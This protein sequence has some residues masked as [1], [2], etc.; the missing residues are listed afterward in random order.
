MVAAASFAGFNGEHFSTECYKQLGCSLLLAL[1]DTHQMAPQQ[2]HQKMEHLRTMLTR[3]GDAD[4]EDSGG[5]DADPTES[6]YAPEE[7]QD[8]WDHF[9]H[10]L[11][12]RMSVQ[13]DEEDEDWQPVALL[14]QPV[15]SVIVAEPEKKPIRK[16]TIRPNPDGENSSS[17]QVDSLERKFSVLLAPVSASAGVHPGTPTV[18]SF[19]EL[20]KGTVLVACC[21][22]LASHRVKSAHRHS[23]INCCGCSAAWNA[24]DWSV[25]KSENQLAGP[26]ATSS[27]W[28]CLHWYLLFSHLQNRLP[29]WMQVSPQ[30]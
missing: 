28:K 18:T 1:H 6:C 15:K 21:A 24:S 2:Q 5:S 16:R 11:P 29:N 25:P 17:L 3:R 7:M 9:E 27:Y 26:E 12:R 19:H 20:G 4:E 10:E 8:V 22:F 30:G 13:E 14:E 23:L